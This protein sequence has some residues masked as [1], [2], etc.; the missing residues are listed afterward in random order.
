LS[1]SWDMRAWPIL[2]DGRQLP[3]KKTLAQSL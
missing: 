1:V 2:P 3:L